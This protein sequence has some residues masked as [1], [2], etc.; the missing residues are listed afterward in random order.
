MFKSS[1]QP[2]SLF[3][4]ILLSHLVARAAID[5]H[6]CDSTKEASAVA[7]VNAVTQDW[8]NSS[9]DVKHR[10]VTDTTV[11][12]SNGLPPYSRLIEWT[13][14]HTAVNPPYNSTV[15]QYKVSACVFNDGQKPSLRSDLIRPRSPALSC[16]SIIDLDTQSLI[17]HIPVVGADFPLSYSTDRDPARALSYQYDLLLN[18]Y[19]ISSSA[20]K[21]LIDVMYDNITETI[22]VSSPSQFKSRYKYLWDG[23]NRS[24]SVAIYPKLFSFELREFP[25]SGHPLG[26]GR[27]N[28]YLGSFNAKSVGLG[29]WTLG[30][31]HYYNKELS[32]LYKGNGE[33]VFAKNMVLANGDV[34]VVDPATKHLLYFN[35]EGKHKETRSNLLNKIIYTFKYNMSGILEE[36]ENAYGRSLTINRDSS[37]NL[38]GITS[39]YGQTTNLQLNSVGNLISVTNPKGDTYAMTYHNEGTGLLS[40]LKKPMGQVSKFSYDYDGRLVKDAR[41]NGPSSSITFSRDLNLDQILTKT[42]S[43]MG[44]QTVHN[45]QNVTDAT[46]IKY[47]RTTQYPSGLVVQHKEDQNDNVNT[48][49]GDSNVITKLSDDPRFPYLMEYTS[50]ITTYHESLP[51]QSYTQTMNISTN[52]GYSGNPF[53]W[54]TY[55]KTYSGAGISAKEI[56]NKNTSTWNLTTFEGRTSSVTLNSSYDRVVEF[57]PQEATPIFY[58]YDGNGQLSSAS[59]GSRGATVNYNSDGLVSSI[60]D[61]LV[62]TTSFIYDLAGNLIKTTLPDN[63][64]VNYTYDSNGKI[65]S[66]QPPGRDKYFYNYGFGSEWLSSLLPPA[67]NSSGSQ[68]TNYFY[69]DDGLMSKIIRANGAQISYNYTVG[70]TKIASITDGIDSYTYS[71]YAS[72]G[73]PTQAISPDGIKSTWVRT[74]PYSQTDKVESITPIK[75]YG[76]A[77]IFYNRHLLSGLR[78]RNS[79]GASAGYAAYT[80]DNDRQMTAAGDLVYSRNLSTGLVDLSSIESFS[81]S[82]T[83]NIYGELD[84]IS[85]QHSSVEKFNYSITR[86]LLGRVDLYTENILGVLSSLDYLYDNSGRLKEVK[87]NGTTVSESIYDANSNRISGKISGVNFTASYNGQDQL[88]SWNNLNFTYNANGERI[89]KIDTS[90]NSNTMYSWDSWGKL[91][92][93]VLPNSDVVSYKYDGA[94]RKSVVSLNGLIKSVYLYNGALQVVAELNAS[95][96]VIS[97]FIWGVHPV[98]PEYFVKGGTKYK[99]ITD[100]R[101]SV[102]LV[103]NTLTGAV[104]QQINYDE[105]GKVVSDT[106]PGFQP[107]G[108][109]GGLYDHR[110]GLVQFGLRHYDGEVGRWI[111]KDSIDF[112]GGDT[113]LY[114]YVISDPVNFVDPIGLWAFQINFGGAGF[115]GLV[116][117]GLSS[118]IAVAGSGFKIKEVNMVTSSQ[119]N[120]GVGASAGRGFQLSFTP[121]AQCLNDIAGDSLS[122]GFD[123][124]LGGVSYSNS[125]IGPTWGIAGPSLGGAVYGGGTRTVIGMPITVN[126]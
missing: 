91:K 93:V 95:G 35:S 101:G 102:R 90:T 55:S 18:P 60:T 106:N 27:T 99:L 107:F 108:F 70:S 88:V 100:P 92:S 68:G 16:G 4:I 81:N 64:E 121:G 47:S 3:F 23:R 103:L 65:T 56:F 73:L 124:P 112:N 67:L 46:S 86:D 77:E 49:Y 118:G 20:T 98:I 61:A 31:H 21:V 122:V 25:S 6:G 119:Y 71:S 74:L 89:S 43:K 59:Q 123:S 17:E 110:T 12:S 96:G 62:Q 39:F 51:N 57:D 114:G 104:A 38:T 78:I 120:M 66:I 7:Y 1:K 42:I 79:S 50:Q 13:E 28:V 36:I 26:R 24:G 69:D 5:A 32:R 2:I 52:P 9:V 63:R 8:S 30:V 37:G 76:T 87:S 111:S 58:S 48:R 72:D 44:R 45:I 75:A 11:P 10:I 40:S 54:N 85:A 115:F 97:R 113:N 41:M 22:E 84:S 53:G 15:Y 19:W 126:P 34:L 29:G 33:T 109:A 125:R 82:Y 83:Y 94:G 14:T 117:A 80:Y 116:G 105:W